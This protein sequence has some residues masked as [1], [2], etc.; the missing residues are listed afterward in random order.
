MSQETIDKYAH[1]LL[2]K[3]IT[4]TPAPTLD[5]LNDFAL[6]L[7]HAGLNQSQ[8]ESIFHKAREST[9]NET[10]DDTLLE[11]L[12]F[13]VGWCQPGKRIFNE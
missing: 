12:D 9:P 2:K 1:R 13:I 7:K 8:V 5:D 11:V 6:L 4:S 3:L 10:V